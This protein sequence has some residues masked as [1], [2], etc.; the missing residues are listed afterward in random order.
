MADS[1]AFLAAMIGALTNAELVKLPVH[2]LDALVAALPA[3]VRNR[4]ASIALAVTGP[5]TGSDTGPTTG[6]STGPTTG[7]GTAARECRNGSECWNK[8]PEHARDFKHPHGW[9]PHKPSS[10]V[11]K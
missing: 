10:A 1:S 6:P 8:K 4:V 2:V 11:S 5:D 3:T 9:T 7:P